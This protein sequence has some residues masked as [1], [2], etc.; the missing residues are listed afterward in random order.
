M[1]CTERLRA[2]FVYYCILL[3]SSTPGIT[4]FRWARSSKVS[5]PSVPGGV[6]VLVRVEHELAESV[7]LPSEAFVFADDQLIAFLRNGTYSF[8]YTDPGQH[9]IWGDT[10]STLDI[11]L[12]AGES[13]WC[14]SRL[15]CFAK[16]RHAGSI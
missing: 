7:C 14:A 15:P 6:P 10:D 3:E 2:R 8:A 5:R 9:M 13:R 4:S 11:H 1:N 12:V 16:N